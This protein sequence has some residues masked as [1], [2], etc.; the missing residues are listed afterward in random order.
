MTINEILEQVKGINKATL[1]EYSFEN[2]EE[3]KVRPIE[4][5]VSHIILGPDGEVNEMS[6]LNHETLSTIYYSSL[7]MLCED[8]WYPVMYSD[9]ND[10]ETLI[11]F[12]KL[13]IDSMKSEEV[14]YYTVGPINDWENS[15]SYKPNFHLIIEKLEGEVNGTENN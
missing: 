4:V 10:K 8:K 15:K 6:F 13:L 14:T 9:K 2:Y 1:Y 11:E 7:D 5:I 3:I 12:K